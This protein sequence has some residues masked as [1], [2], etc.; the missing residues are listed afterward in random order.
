MALDTASSSIQ[1]ALQGAAS[2]GAAAGGP[3]ALAGGL[4]GLVGGLFN[5]AKGERKTV[6]NMTLQHIHNQVETKE[7]KSQDEGQTE[8]KTKY[9][10]TANIV[11]SAIGSLPSILNPSYTKNDYTL[12]EFVLRY[13]DLPLQMRVQYNENLAER[14][15]MT[16][17]LKKN[18]NEVFNT[19][20]I[21]N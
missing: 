7:D 17:T 3:G 11:S 10:G 21:G 8:R 5:M 4:A 16:K 14:Y 19:E 13:N 12:I 18:G 2:G 9:V 20:R 6:E 15:T 1:G